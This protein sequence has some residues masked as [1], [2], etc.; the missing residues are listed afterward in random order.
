MNI[1]LHDAASIVLR[2]KDGSLKE[3]R[4]VSDD[5]EIASYT[6]ENIREVYIPKQKFR[7]NKKV[8]ESETALRF[9]GKI[10]ETHG[11]S[12]A[13][14]DK[15]LPENSPVDCIAVETKTNKSLL[16]Q[17]RTSDDEPIKDLMQGKMVHRSGKRHEIHHKTIRRAIFSKSSKYPA[18]VK[19]GLILL[20]DGWLG[21]QQEDLNEFK[22]TEREF[23][24]QTG[25]DEV[26]FVG[27]TVIDRLA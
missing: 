5:H 22:S 23:L 27:G 11:T 16:L 12:F 20:L 21:V 25:F 19:K 10:N 18:E 2:D 9:L 6:A 3:H 14:S 24:N 13:L 8:G 15:P 7:R 17:V 26:W 1:T 4:H